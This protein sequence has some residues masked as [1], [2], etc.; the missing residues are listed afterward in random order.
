MAVSGSDVLIDYDA[1]ATTATTMGNKLSDISNE[2][3]SLEDTVSG[4]LQE[5]LVFEKASPAL[6][7]AYTQFTTQMKSSAANIQAYADN[8]KGIATSIADSDEKMM[9][10]IRKAT[11][12]AAAEA[13]KNQ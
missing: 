12:E 11:A 1:I 8:F 5:G 9:A 2:L 6:Q 3:K 7:E 13:A 10:E 4:L